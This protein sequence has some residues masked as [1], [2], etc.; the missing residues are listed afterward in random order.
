MI[1]LLQQLEACLAGTH[2]SLQCYVV[3]ITFWVVSPER[4]TTLSP[5]GELMVPW[6]W[7]PSCAS[8]CVHSQPRWCLKTSGLR[9][10]AESVK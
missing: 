5:P 1:A 7:L 3:S 2:F 4:A 10:A 6:W 8:I 9:R